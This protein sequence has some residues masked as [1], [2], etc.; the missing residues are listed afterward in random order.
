MVSAT[1]GH[2]SDALSVKV[3]FSAVSRRWVRVEAVAATPAP[4]RSPAF[5]KPAVIDSFNEATV[6]VKRSASDGAERDSPA[7]EGEPCC[8]V[9]HAASSASEQTVVSIFFMDIPVWINVS[10]AICVSRA[11]V[12]WYMNHRCWIGL[13]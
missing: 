8:G 9:A 1:R 4:G 12:N 3:S 10:V 5:V 2:L 6:E 11:S 13:R 7:D